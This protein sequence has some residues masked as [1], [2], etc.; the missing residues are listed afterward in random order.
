MDGDYQLS[1]S[2]IVMTPTTSGGADAF[3]GAAAPGWM[4]TPEVAPKITLQL[5]KPFAVEPTLLEELKIYGNVKTL[6]V[7]VQTS[8]TGDF[9][10]YKDNIDVTS[11]TLSFV[12][13]TNKG[14]MVFAVQISLLDT[15]TSGLPFALRLQV[16]ACVKGK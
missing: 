6:S 4:V 14:I 8:P 12:E 1:D 7:S 2:R 11:G 16:F 13:G 9:E 3:R 15:S 5:T 10:I